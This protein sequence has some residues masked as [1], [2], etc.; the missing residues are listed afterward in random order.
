MNCYITNKKV[1]AKVI[2][3]SSLLHRTLLVWSSQ[4]PGFEM[5]R[6]DHWV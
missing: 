3:K 2:A 1:M 4:N 6:G 5:E